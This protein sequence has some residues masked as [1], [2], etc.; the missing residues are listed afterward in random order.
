MIL[1]KT[2]RR[3][4]LLAMLIAVGASVNDRSH[5]SAA[6]ILVTNAGRFGCEYAEGGAQRSGGW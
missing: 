6:D 3:R 1:R 4:L 5:V 2:N